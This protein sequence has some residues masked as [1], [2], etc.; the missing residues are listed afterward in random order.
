[1]AVAINQLIELLELLLH[2]ISSQNCLGMTTRFKDSSL[3][4][5]SS[6]FE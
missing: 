3:T 6:Y 4:E 5:F 2:E 1:V